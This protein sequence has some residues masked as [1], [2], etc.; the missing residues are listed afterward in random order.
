M[1]SKNILLPV[2]AILLTNVALAYDRGGGGGMEFRHDDMD[3]GSDRSMFG[4]GHR[5][6][7]GMYHHDRQTSTSRTIDTPNGNY[8]VNNTVNHQSPTKEQ[9]NTTVTDQKNGQSYSAQTQYN[10]VGDYGSVNS[11]ITNNNNN[12]SYTVNAS[13]SLNG[14]S[15]STITN[16]QT[17]KTYTGSQAVNQIENN[18]QTTTTYY[19]SPSYYGTSYY[20]GGY[21]YEPYPV[22]TVGVGIPMGVPGSSS[23]NVTNN[24]YTNNSQNPNN[25]VQESNIGGLYYY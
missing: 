15:Q 25:A 12:H 1:K 8:Q 22:Y 10:H 16:N 14:T 19:S 5:Q 17:G 11:T 13:H 7:D 21:Y 6:D 3:D 18:H 9:V 2:F 20:G 23:T 4:G 24:Y